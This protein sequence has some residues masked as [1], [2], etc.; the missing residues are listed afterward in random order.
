MGSTSVLTCPLHALVTYLVFDTV[1]KQKN[2][3]LKSCLLECLVLLQKRAHCV[4]P[5]RREIV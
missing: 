2:K 5:L 1:I 3:K 4:L